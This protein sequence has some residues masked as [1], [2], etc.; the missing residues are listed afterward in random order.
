[1]VRSED[2]RLALEL[3]E[4]SELLREALVLRYGEARSISLAKQQY[5]YDQLVRREESALYRD[6]YGRFARTDHS[7]Y[8]G[9]RLSSPYLDEALSN[10][11]GPPKSPWPDGCSAAICFTHDVDHCGGWVSCLLRDAFY[12]LQRAKLGLGFVEEGE[13]ERLEKRICGYRKLRQQKISPYDNID[14]W[15]ELESSLG[16]KSAFYFLS[17]L[18]THL[19]TEG[20]RYLISSSRMKR[21]VRR[22]HDGGWEVGL[23]ARRYRPFSKSDLRAQKMRLEDAMG[24][25]LF[26]IRNHY[27]RVRFPE[28]WCLHAESGFRYSSNMG[29]PDD[30][31]GFRAGTCWPYRPIRRHDFWEVPFQMMDVEAAF[32]R[33]GAFFDRF[34]QFLSLIKKHC[35]VLV[36]D[37]HSDN[38]FDEIA[39]DVNAT[40]RRI[41]TVV[42]SDPELWVATPIQVTKRLE[43]QN[44]RMDG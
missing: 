44:R 19:L 27:L 16:I 3:K 39:P 32:Y 23:H 8:Q 15:M 14:R 33:S 37:F 6:H 20:N 9:G 38:F 34:E 29:W 13:R 22:L 40:Y 28:S 21:L 35:G 30:L 12:R 4:P 2:V 31:G 18:P 1:M 7:C 24:S 36:V 10:E 11:L 17:L 5:F 41:A 43:E 26:G 42:G 25:E